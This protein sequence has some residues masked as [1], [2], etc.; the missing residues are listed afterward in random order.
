MCCKSCRQLSPL[1]F[2][3][4]SFS[5]A[6][7]CC[8]YYDKIRPN[9]ML[10]LASTSP[11]RRELLSFTGLSFEI[12]P[13]YVDERVHEGESP[14]GYVLRLAEDKVRKVASTAARKITPE[15]L[16]IGADTTVVEKS[17]RNEN[18]FHILGKPVDAADAERTLRRLRGRKHWV[19]TGVAVYRPS[20]DT[21]ETDVCVTEVPMRDYSDEEI[22]AYVRSGDPMDKAGAYAIQSKGFHPVQNLQGCYA[23]VMGLPVCHLV[24]LLRRFSVFPSGDIPWVCRT[25]LGFV[26]SYYPYVLGR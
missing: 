2:Y 25:E 20:D 21:L 9:H 15:T 3:N 7:H 26:C 14:D 23:N 17:L 22:K 10:I 19:Y 18:K 13:A 12:L 5:N 11:R 1:I 16:V 24:R 6:N 8:G 4:S